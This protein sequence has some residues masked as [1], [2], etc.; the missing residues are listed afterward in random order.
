VT[1]NRRGVVRDGSWGVGVLGCWGVGCWVLGVGRPEAGLFQSQIKTFLKTSAF[2]DPT[3]GLVAPQRLVKSPTAVCLDAL[4]ANQK[5]YALL[6]AR[7]A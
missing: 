6:M 5:V 1:A 4:V 7:K 2:G 3:L